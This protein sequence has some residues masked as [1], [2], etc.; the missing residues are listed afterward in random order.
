MKKYFSNFTLTAQK[1]LLFASLL[2][3]VTPTFAQTAPAQKEEEII[4]PHRLTAGFGGG[5]NLNLTSGNYVLDN[6]SYSS[7]SGIGPVFYALLEIP[8]ADHWKIAPR[9]AYNNFSASF[10]DG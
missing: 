5:A 10:T 6:N 8:I 4:W 9:L 1:V 3:L 7:G 2:T